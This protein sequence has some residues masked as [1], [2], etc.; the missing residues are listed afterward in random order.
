VNSP[1]ATVIHS[2]DMLALRVR[3]PRSRSTGV[4][5]LG[6]RLVNGVARQPEILRNSRRS[7]R[8]K[9]S[10]TLR[11][12]TGSSYPHAARPRVIGLRRPDPDTGP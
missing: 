9:L 5:G 6:R 1:A 10:I 2:L 8:R 7:A 3:S 11:M 12:S 4:A